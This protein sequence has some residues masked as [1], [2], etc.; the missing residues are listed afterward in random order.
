MHSDIV[1]PKSP[2]LEYWFGQYVDRR[3]AEEEVKKRCA[4]GWTFDSIQAI[5]FTTSEYITTGPGL[6]KESKE[7]LVVKS[8]IYYLIT[9]H[10]ISVENEDT[11]YVV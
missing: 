7:T 2:P 8:E 5:P 3:W 6:N 4:K 11:D 9:M 1:P 10:R